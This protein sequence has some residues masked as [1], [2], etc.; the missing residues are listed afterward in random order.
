LK[1]IRILYLAQASHKGSGIGGGAR[2][3][4]TINILNKFQYKYGLIAY[5]F[6]S[7]KFSIDLENNNSN[8][9][10]IIHIPQYLPNVIKS[11]FMI[12]YIFI[13]LFYIKKSQVI[14]SDFNNI[15]CSLPAIILGKI[16]NIPVIL[17][18][19]DTKLNK[20]IPDLI[21]N[22]LIKEST[23]IYVIS[24][25]LFNHFSKVVNSDKIFYYP[26]SVDTDIF[27]NNNEY[28][29]EVRS[30]IDCPDDTILIC[31]AGS[32][33]SYEG[34]SILISAFKKVIEGA[35]NVK[36]VI[37]GKIIWKNKDE[38]VEN[39]IFDQQLE[40]SVIF[41][42]LKQHEEMPKYLSAMDILCCPKIDCEINRAAN[43]VKVIEYLSMAKPVIASS[44][45]EIPIII[46]DNVNG[47][48]VKPGDVEDLYNKI[49]FL[50]KDRS[51]FSKVG[52]EARNSIINNYD[53]CVIGD[54]ISNNLLKILNRS[55]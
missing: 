53:H 46:T 8:T 47:F 40:K 30:E 29:F 9:N 21:Y 33:T 18:S 39:F 42:G 41:L 11:L 7:K 28:R 14:L 12:P 17:D 51:L 54:K 13:S 4:N 52:F 3:K 38:N 34:V 16:F 22:Y 6:Y 25:Y 15:L 48:L 10:I 24:H 32:F 1:D 37:I 45:G 27:K 20:A 43:P 50:I 31:Y 23:Q 19:I 35:H 49:I 5:D 2:V 55:N 44:V 26:I 36:L